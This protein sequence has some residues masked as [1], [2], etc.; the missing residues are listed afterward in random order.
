METLIIGLVVLGVLV[1]PH[2]LGHL[3]AG[4][5]LR[6]RVVRFSVGFGPQVV[7]LRWRG[8][9]WVVGSVPLGGYVKFA[10]DEPKEMD[11]PP[12]PDEFLGK[13]WW[14]KM[15]V[16]LAGPSSNL[17]LAFTL[18]FVLGMVGLRVPDPSL[19]IGEV[20]D[21]SPASRYGLRPGD[22][23]VEV[24][25]RGATS[26]GELAQAV[27]EWRRSGAPRPLA[28][29]VAREGRVDTLWVETPDSLLEG[30]TLAF[31]PVV[32]EVTM[33]YPAFEAGLQQGDSLVSVD[34]QPVR[35][36]Q[37]VRRIVQQKPDAELV[38]QFVRGGR[39]M[40]TTVR[41]VSGK[42]VG[43]SGGFIGIM[44]PEG[45]TR[46]VRY[47]PARALGYAGRSTLGMVASVYGGFATLVHNPS[48]LRRQLGGPIAIVR[49]SSRQARKGADSFVGFV[50]LLSVMLAVLNLLPIPVLDGAMVVFSLV[51]GLRRKPLGLKTQLWLQRVGF[52]LLILLMTF[53]FA[54]DIGRELTR[55]RAAGKPT[56]VHPGEPGARGGGQ[57]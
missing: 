25:G 8:I 30:V 19:V 26:L 18:L 22:Q 47:G 46:L 55:V 7:G 49:F 21:S 27:D 3:L 31:P 5:A 39:L 37:D 33:G 57:G 54:N 2:E 13:P 28:V 52:G 48:A 44:A 56:E 24:G 15:V 11:R 34:G 6:V 23:V 51:E 40:E 4:L 41:P 43:Q 45:R 35:T 53:A 38:V 16:A 20:A 50:A 17:V 14:V 36:F 10:G 9:Q 1:I 12:G 42:T 32:G 29:A